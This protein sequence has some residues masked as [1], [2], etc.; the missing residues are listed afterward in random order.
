MSKLTRSEAGKRGYI[1]ALPQLRQQCQERIDQYNDN[2]KRCKYCGKPLPYKKRNN[3]FCNQSCAASY[4]N[5]IKKRTKKP[6][7]VCQNCG[8]ILKSKQFK[9]CSNKCQK[10]F[11][12]K[13][14]IN[15]WKVGKE[16]G[17]KGVYSLSGHIRHYLLEKVGNKCERCGWHEIN[18]TT[19]KIPL[20]I[21]HIDGDYC[22]N[23]E[24]NLQVLCPNCHSLTPNYKSVNRNGRKERKKYSKNMGVPG[25]DS[26]KP[27]TNCT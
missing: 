16:N 11:Q 22:N 8:K 10:E 7:K 24:S 17:V 12:R 23:T 19:G 13:E 26:L 27:S 15:R 14:Y 25:I 1:K 5:P 21:H 6:V 3:T 20:E 9:Y 4:N 2:P 18:S